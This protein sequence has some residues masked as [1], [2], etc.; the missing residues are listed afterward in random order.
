[1]TKIK[2]AA[3]DYLLIKKQADWHDI[4]LRQLIEAQASASG[5]TKNPAGKNTTDRSN[6]EEGMQRQAGLRPTSNM[7]QFNTSNSTNRGPQQQENH[8][9]VGIHHGPRGNKVDG[10]FGLDH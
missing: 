10:L 2:E 3:K 5:T 4:W 9:Y 7:P 1:M 8:L 6:T